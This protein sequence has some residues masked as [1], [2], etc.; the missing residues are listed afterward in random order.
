MD[1]GKANHQI[2]RRLEFLRRP[3]A[4]RK[5]AKKKQKKNPWMLLMN[6]EKIQKK[7]KPGR[8]K[9]R[10]NP[11]KILLNPLKMSSPSVCT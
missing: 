11:E 8:S 1:T 9:K 6:P 2:C 10:Y 3:M 7:I 4:R 5:T